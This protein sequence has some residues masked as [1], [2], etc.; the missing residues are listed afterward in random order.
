M[1]ADSAAVRDYVL[2]FHLSHLLDGISFTLRDYEY[3]GFD[4]TMSDPLVE[5][6]S[7]GS[8][9]AVTAIKHVREL[10]VQFSG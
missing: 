7:E 8:E 10:L 1:A 5:L 9:S 6:H 4:F 2:L 3:V